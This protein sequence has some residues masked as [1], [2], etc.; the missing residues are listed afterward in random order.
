MF[1]DDWDELVAQVETHGPEKVIFI[2]END[3]T[4]EPL[5]FDGMSVKFESSEGMIVVELGAI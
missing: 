1:K 2:L 3:E 5:T 4:R